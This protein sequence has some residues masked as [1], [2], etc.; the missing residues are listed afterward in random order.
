MSARDTFWRIVLL[1]APLTVLSTFVLWPLLDSFRYSFTDWNGFDDNPNFVGL[2]NFLRVFSDPLF[3]G[4][5][6]NTAIWMAAALAVPTLGGLT[7]ALLLDTGL[8]GGRFF[9]SVFYLP[10]CLSAVVVGQIWIWIFQPDWGLLNATIRLAAGTSAQQFDWAWLAQPSTALA[11]VILAWSWQQTGLTMVIFLAGLTS[12]PSELLEAADI[13]NVPRGKQIRHII[14]PMLRPTTVVAV[15]LSVIGALKTFDI[16]YI[17]TGGGPFHSSD[18]LALFMYEESFK[19][20]KM[21]Y[22]SS[23]SVV[24]FLI[25]LVIIV[26]YFRQIGRLKEIYD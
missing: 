16:L 17:M 4:S 13:D 10:I 19:K 22:G 26:I 23:I 11:S 1:A 20:Y 21:G 24:L 7:L 2:T 18:T 25:C 14:L 9:K 3:F 8:R 6:I 5:L 12:I 15:A